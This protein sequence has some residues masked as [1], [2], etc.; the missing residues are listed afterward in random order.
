MAKET[1]LATPVAAATDAQPAPAGAL[2]KIETAEIAPFR[3]ENLTQAARLATA[4]A[5]SSVLP[6]PLRGKPADVLVVLITGHELGLSP[7]QS[8]RGMHV[9]EGKAVM[10]SEMMAGL[11]RSRATICQYLQMVES[12]DQHATYETHR[13]GDPKPTRLSYTIEQATKAGLA[14]KDNW[15]RHP[16]AML[17]ARCLSAI[18]R[19]VYSDLVN[20]V[21][22]LD[23]ADEI[24]IRNITP[25]QARL[26][27]GPG[28]KLDALTEMLRT[29][30]EAEAGEEAVEDLADEPSPAAAPT[31][32][33][34]PARPVA[35]VAPGSLSGS[36]FVDGLDPETPATAAPVTPAARPAAGPAQQA[37]ADF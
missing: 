37:L 31:A 8:I 10:A 36:D 18:C 13:K 27:P 23:E 4:L 7:M 15:K 19:A 1:K 28:T 26:E 2:A 32:A 25:R 24:G 34:R 29:Q 3:P 16:A 21:Y 14:S 11:V 30:P 17:R 12:D 22:D 35:P 33:V 5:R 6:T 9:I 20:G